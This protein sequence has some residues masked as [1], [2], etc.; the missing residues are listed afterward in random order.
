MGKFDGYVLLSDV[1]GT[2]IDKNNTVLKKDEDA[3]NYF[4]S[5]G[6]RFTFASG[7]L[8]GGL[9]CVLHIGAD[10]PIICHNGAVIYDMNDDRLLWSRPLE[11]EKLFP[12]VDHVLE[13][14]K[15]CGIQI[16]CERNVFVVK[17]NPQTMYHEKIEEF[18]AIE[19]AAED[20]DEEWIKFMLADEPEVIEVIKSELEHSEYAESFRCV[21]SH[22]FFFE[23]L[24]KG[25]SKGAA[26]ARYSD[27]S[28]ISADKI[29]AIGDNDNDAEMIKAAKIGAAVRNASPYAKKNADIVL[30]NTNTEGAVAEFIEL[31]DKKY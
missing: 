24:S 14:Y 4:R 29:F 2:L 1:D 10:L 20:I 17:R 8:P 5:E 25:V 11:K 16:V 27:F 7:R 28:N 6:G 31:L 3:V 18:C 26:L 22:E 13:N 15:T 19:K 21:R 12:L 9:K 30:K 23:L